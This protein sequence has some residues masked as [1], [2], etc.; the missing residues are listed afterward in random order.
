MN[1]WLLLVKDIFKYEDQM[2]EID[3]KK[4]EG[5]SEKEVIIKKSHNI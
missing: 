1:R 4:Y 3:D 5:M 2:R